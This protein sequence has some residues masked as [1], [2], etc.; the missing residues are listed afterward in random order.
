MSLYSVIQTQDERRLSELPSSCFARSSIDSHHREELKI[1]DAAFKGR[2][3][4]RLA[5]SSDQRDKALE[6]NVGNPQALDYKGRRWP[7]DWS[8]S[9]TSKVSVATSAERKMAARLRSQSGRWVWR[10]DAAI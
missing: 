8:G 7:D 6:R 3:D 5:F 10:G 2:L 4:S 1:Q 9:G